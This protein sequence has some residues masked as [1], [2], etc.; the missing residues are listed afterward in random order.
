MTFCRACGKF[1][2][3]KLGN[4]GSLQARGVNPNTF[5][6][7]AAAMEAGKRAHYSV[8]YAAIGCKFRGLAMERGGRFGP[9]LLQLVKECAL[10]LGG[11]GWPMSAAGLLATWSNDSFVRF[12]TQRII[13]AVQVDTCVK[14]LEARGRVLGAVPLLGLLV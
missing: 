7:Y 5:P 1:F 8:R 2:D 14:L 6:S 4:E 11:E 10:R 9:N 12:W 13:C 3:F